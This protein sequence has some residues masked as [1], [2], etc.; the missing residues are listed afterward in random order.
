MK[1]FNM[2]KF[3]DPKIK[4]NKENKTNKMKFVLFT[5][6]VVLLCLGTIN[7]IRII[8]FLIIILIIY[9]YKLL[10][11][12]F[13][14]NKNNININEYLIYVLLFI[15][16]IKL[17]YIHIINYIYILLFDLT[18]TN[19]NKNLISLIIKIIKYLILYPMIVIGTKFYMVLLNW[20]YSSI[21]DI[22]FNRL[23]GVIL[24][25]LIFSP[26][27]VYIYILMNIY[28]YISLYI[29]LILLI[30][31]NNNIKDIVKYKYLKIFMFILYLNINIYMFLLIE[32]RCR[33]SILVIIIN[34]SSEN[35]INHISI[36]N[37]YSFNYKCLYWN[38]GKPIRLIINYKSEL[39][40]YKL[41]IM[42]DSLIKKDPYLILY[43]CNKFNFILIEYINF[44]YNIEYR[45]SNITFP[46]SEIELEK[47]NKLKMIVKKMIKVLLSFFIYLY[48]LIQKDKGVDLVELNI[49]IELFYNI[50]WM[51]C[52][53]AYEKP[54]NL[55]HEGLNSLYKIII[56]KDF[57]NYYEIFESLYMYGNII[58]FY[59]FKNIGISV[60]KDNSYILDYIEYFKELTKALEVDEKYMDIDYYKY[61]RIDQLEIEDQINLEICKE[62]NKI[63]KECVNKSKSEDIN[64]ELFFELLIIE[65]KEFKD[66]MNKVANP[67]QSIKRK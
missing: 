63:I 6:W 29:I 38:M 10:I 7:I 11:S 54:Y 1:P 12:Y 36:V 17:S 55:F 59:K 15:D 8:T 44:L 13:D 22:I 64:K 62:I 49:S 65:I 25:V 46:L 39:K 66:L 31:I 57:I 51:S 26:V 61:M 34:K 47:L 19:I 53:I 24:S 40:H 56:N 42:W 28:V 5:L 33:A 37:K 3:L 52:Y 2:L 58:D 27:Y 21:K 23:F 20:K 43:C 4:E 48:V 35:I 16:N 67:M 14:D 60:N 18:N 41:C 45:L 9:I 32:Y 30:I 50:E